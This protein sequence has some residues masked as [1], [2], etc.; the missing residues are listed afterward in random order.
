MQLSEHGIKNPSHKLGIIGLY[1]TVNL[2]V[3]NR[4]LDGKSS[5]TVQGASSAITTR[6]SVIMN[7]SAEAPKNCLN[8]IFCVN[9]FLCLK[10]CQQ[11]VSFCVTFEFFRSRKNVTLY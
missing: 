6:Q 10:V 3:D 1:P 11:T 4:L 9:T 2:I 5:H 7:F 8:H